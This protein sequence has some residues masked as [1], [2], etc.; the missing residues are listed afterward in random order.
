MS[1]YACPYTEDPKASK[2]LMMCI[3]VP[4]QRWYH[5]VCFGRLG[6][7]YEDGGCEHTD[8]LLARLTDH[9]KSVVKVQSFGDGKRVPKRF[10]KRPTN[11]TSHHRTRDG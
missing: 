11:R 3:R 6:H 4:G 2:A 10:K 5:A 7:Y 8:A 9:G 1:L